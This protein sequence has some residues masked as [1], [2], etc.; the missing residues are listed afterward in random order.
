[1]NQNKKYKN[2]HIQIHNVLSEN[3]DAFLDPFLKIVCTYPN[4]KAKTD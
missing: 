2:K 1:M 3:T 4:C